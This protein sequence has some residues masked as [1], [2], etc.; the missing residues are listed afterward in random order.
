MLTGVD[1]D[2]CE[3]LLNAEGDSQYVESLAQ[4]ISAKQ[5]I[6]GYNHPAYPGGDPRGMFLLE[7]A[8]E[9]GVC[10][11]AN[12]F[13]TRIERAS[14]TLG[15]A[16]SVAAG[17]AVVCDCLNMPKG[18]AGALMALSRTVGWIAHAFEQRDSGYLIRPR[19][20]YIG[21]K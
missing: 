9:T 14:S 12:T 2:A 8:R 5:A 19:G 16:P 7:I 1:C 10:K 13:L 17:L 11:N 15:I 18:S 4:L 3:R 21:V 20:R 6:P